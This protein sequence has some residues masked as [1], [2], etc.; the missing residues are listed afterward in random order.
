MADAATSKP[1][2]A[3]VHAQAGFPINIEEDLEP[4]G[5]CRE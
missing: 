1:V 3:I 4:E 2:G 5:G